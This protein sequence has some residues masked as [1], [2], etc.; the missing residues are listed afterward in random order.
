MDAPLTGGSGTVF[1]ATF[2]PRS[3]VRMGDEVEVGFD[4]E[5]LHLFDPETEMNLRQAE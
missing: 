2:E 1:C 5:R 4:V 3:A